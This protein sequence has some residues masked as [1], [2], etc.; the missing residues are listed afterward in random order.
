MSFTMPR[1]WRCNGALRQI[2]NRQASEKHVQSR[3]HGRERGPQHSGLRRA[4]QQKGA[5]VACLAA[6]SMLH[7]CYSHG[8]MQQVEEGRGKC[9]TLASAC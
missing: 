1:S 8:Y 7:P 3:C 9:L 4:G 5:Q 6:I 2:S